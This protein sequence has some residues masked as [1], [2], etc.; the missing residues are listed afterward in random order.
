MTSKQNIDEFDYYDKILNH[1][2]KT[3]N[4][5]ITE[6]TELFSSKQIINI[7]Q[8]L[9]DASQNAKQNRDEIENIAKNTLVLLISLFTQKDET[10]QYQDYAALNED[11]KR[12]LKSELSPILSIEN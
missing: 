12:R 11:E 7:M 1:Y 3:K 6:D 5:G 8:Q 2:E 4:T 10:V 9:K